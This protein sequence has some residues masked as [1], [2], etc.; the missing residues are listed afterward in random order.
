MRMI[1]IEGKYFET[2]F[3]LEF[4]RILGPL[5]RQVI[6]LIVNSILVHAVPRLTIQLKIITISITFVLTLSMLI[7][8]RQL[9]LVATHTSSHA[10]N[11]FICLS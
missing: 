3:T 9:R 8:I 5:V 2:T 4:S 6:V 10:L 1:Q 11:K 7:L